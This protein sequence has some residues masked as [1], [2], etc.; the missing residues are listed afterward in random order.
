MDPLSHATLGGIASTLTCRRREW[1]GKAAL[2]GMLAGMSPDLD[3]LI[4]ES[5]NPM[6]GLAYHRHF[7]HALAFAPIGAL[8]IATVFWLLLRR[9]IPLVPVYIFCLAGI[10]VH[11][12]LDAMTNYGTHWL[13]PFTNRRESWSIISIIDPVFT[14]TLCAFLLLSVFKKNRRYALY[15]LI[16]AVCYWGLGWHQR[17]TATQEM[18]AQAKARGHVAER[19]EVKPSLGN[20]VVW[21]GQYQFEGRIYID[22]YHVSPWGGKKVYAG[23]TLP[24]YAPPTGLSP[25]Q[26]RDWD[27]FYFFSDGWVAQTPNYPGLVGDVRFAM[28]P[29]QIYPIWGIEFRPGEPDEHVIFRNIRTRSPGDI[30]RLWQM[31]KGHDVPQ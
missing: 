21:R 6:L 11:G 19:Y 1:I 15:G 4:R 2:A 12:I 10:I 3:I 20:L 27:Y 25:T 30:N 29:N 5:G 18:L 28:L 23:D 14:L 8:V 26:Q 9:R 13:W 22:A 7:T 17:E 16:F 24:V 31:I